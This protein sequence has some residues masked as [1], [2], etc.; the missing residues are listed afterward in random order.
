MLGFA[1][2]LFLSPGEQINHTYDSSLPPGR[3]GSY[4]GMQRE[5]VLCK[6]NQVKKIINKNMTVL[7]LDFT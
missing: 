4:T 1:V 7:A 3:Q 6:T 2:C 5:Y